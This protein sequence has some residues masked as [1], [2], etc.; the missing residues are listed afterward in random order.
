MLNKKKTNKDV[1]LLAHVLKT[2]TTALPWEWQRCNGSSA[3]YRYLCWRA[4]PR[5]QGSGCSCRTQVQA[6][7]KMTDQ[8]AGMNPRNRQISSTKGTL[9]V[10]L[11]TP[12]WL[13]LPQILT[14]QEQQVSFYAIY[15]KRVFP[16]WSMP[17]PQP[18][19]PKCSLHPLGRTETHHC[20][21][22]CFNKGPLRAQW[23]KFWYEIA[24][25]Q[26][27]THWPLLWTS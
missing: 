18:L 17:P 20:S 5:S 2:D 4:A 6:G 10:P 3:R 27:V 15:C 24:Y 8:K 21:C 14:C 12:F 16:A 19:F 9:L 11:S 1:T 26:L 25:R 7:D 23:K 13:I 22:S